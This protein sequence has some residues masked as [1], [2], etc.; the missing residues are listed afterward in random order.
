MRQNAA[1]LAEPQAFRFCFKNLFQQNFSLNR[2]LTEMAEFAEESLEK[3]LPAFESIKSLNLLG[4]TEFNAFVQQC[5]R[6]EYRIQKRV[7][8]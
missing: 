1:Q 5:N 6:F 3:L 2:K 7:C 4:A 8:L